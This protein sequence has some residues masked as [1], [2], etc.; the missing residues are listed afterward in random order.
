MQ[1]LPEV[2]GGAV[3]APFRPVNPQ[4]LRK[5]LPQPFQHLPGEAGRLV[6]LGAKH[7]AQLVDRVVA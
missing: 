5:L 6:A 7:R 2:V 3:D 1:A 4:V